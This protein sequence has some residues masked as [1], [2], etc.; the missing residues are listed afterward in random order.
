[1]LFRL[2]SAAVLF[3]L[4]AGQANADA[5]QELRQLMAEYWEDYLE[6]NPLSANLFGDNRN[7]TKL[8]DVSLESFD[9]RRVFLDQL[10]TQVDAIDPADLDAH[11]R[12]QQ[13]I[14]RWM[15]GKTRRTL[16]FNNHYFTFNT[17]SGWHTSFPSV[18]SA[19]SYTSEQ[20]YRDLLARYAAFPVFAE[21]NMALMR[22]GLETGYTQ[23]CG[24]LEGYV[25]TITGYIA[26]D[27]DSSVFFQP[28]TRMPEGIDA[29]VAEELKQLARQQIT[30]SI[31]PGYAAYAEFFERDYA[32]GCRPAAGLSTVPD[33]RALYDHLLTYY[34]SLETDADTVHMLGLSE[35]KR[36]R[37]DMQSILEELEFE[38]GLDEFRA[39]LKTDPQF[40]A[41]TEEEYL[42][43]VAWIAKGIDGKL[44]LYFARLPSIPYGIK[45]V[46]EQT[47]PKT[48]TAYY[49]P[50]AVDGSRA[51]FYFANTYNLPERPLYELPALT[52]HEAVPGHHLQFSFQAQN[53]D[54]P[55]WR[56]SF[57]F[58]AFGEGWALY[59]EL[60]GEE[61]G[62]YNTP[63]ERFGRMIY[64]M[65]RA[66]RLVVDTGLHAK[67]WTRQQ[68]IDYVMENTGLAE[69]N[70]IAEVDRYITYPGQAT[71]Y[72]HGELKI[73]ELRALAEERL[74]DDFDL[75]EFHV[76]VLKNGSMPLTVL[77]QRIVDW[78]V[79]Q[80]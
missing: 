28:F 43:H 4:L 52:L 53:T 38:G 67:G 1:M 18:V 31:N 78:I 35:V 74:G 54:M 72:K 19:L 6:T 16:D 21:Q 34:T 32:P 70:V 5:N 22:A 61:M 48:A 26:E 56:R 73:R 11:N 33:G 24:V 44:P 42:A 63:Y 64:E 14:F 66:V 27:V 59:T 57:Y 20:D 29:E 3:F 30:E 77:E 8:N 7:R 36:I 55:D 69:A 76:E 79:S 50:A 45:P 46:P 13:E 9:R 23:A 10:I 71:A 15:L 62:V 17:F 75:R 58:H 39:F 60:L 65:W 25:D 37:A 47:A 12:E 2:F 41:D 80:Q 40:Y 51:G 49:Q 68:A